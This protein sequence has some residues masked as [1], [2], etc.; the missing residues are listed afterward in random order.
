VQFTGDN[1]AAGTFVDDAGAV[2][3]TNGIV[4]SSGDVGS[5]TG[6][7]DDDG[8]STGFGL[9]GDADLD[10]ISGNS[11]KT[12]PRWNSTS[13]RP[14]RRSPSR[15]SSRPK[16]T[17]EY[18]NFGFNDVFGFFVNGTNLALL[19]DGVTP[20]SID[21]VNGGKPRSCAPCRQSS[22]LRQQRLRRHTLARSTCRPTDARSRSSFAP[23]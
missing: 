7:N 6:P 23:P 12:R 18:A 15:T 5:I 20:V 17:N 9:P 16:S 14:A 1:L 21:T 8:F 3:L 10:S 13:Y 19:P 2:G 11:P 22:L 4:L